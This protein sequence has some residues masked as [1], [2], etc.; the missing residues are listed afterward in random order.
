M[1]EGDRKARVMESCEPDPP[2][3]WRWMPDSSPHCSAG[4]RCTGH[5]PAADPAGGLPPPHGRGAQEHQAGE[6]CSG[7]GPQAPC[8]QTGRSRAGRA[9][10]C[11]HQGRRSRAREP[12]RVHRC[13]APAPCKQL[14][15][16]HPVTHHPP[17]LAV[18]ATGLFL[19]LRVSLPST[20]A[21]LQS[22]QT[23]P[24]PAKRTERTT[25]SSILPRSAILLSQE[26]HRGEAAAPDLALCS[27]RRRCS[28]ATRTIHQ[29][30]TSGP[31]GCACMP[32]CLAAFPM[33][34]PMTSGLASSVCRMSEL[35][36]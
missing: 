23:L 31:A 21:R 3:V 1:V 24:L 33:K 6:H 27:Q 16:D 29:R 32:C 8:R 2:S 35:L 10:P 5:P 17:R 19:Q 22:Q 7:R 14:L 34:A 15:F 11:Q 30:Q 18:V 4:A 25:G 9:A 26:S 12:C 20:D 28:R 36:L 13:S